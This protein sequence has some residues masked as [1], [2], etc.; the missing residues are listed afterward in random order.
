MKENSSEKMFAG[1]L[2]GSIALFCGYIYAGVKSPEPGVDQDLSSGLTIEK[3]ELKTPDGIT[4]RPKRYANPSG[5]PVL[6]LHGISGNGFEFDIPREEHNMAVFL[7][8]RGYDCWVSSF[9]GCGREPYLS[10][11]DDLSHSMDHLAIY[12]APTLVDGIIEKTGKKPFWIGHSMGGMTLYMYLQGARFEEPYHVVS[13]PDLVKERNSKLLGGIPIASP[14]AFRWSRAH[15]FNIAARSRLGRNLLGAGIALMRLGGLASPKVKI[16]SLALEVTG[17]RPKLIKALSRSPVGMQLYCRRN[18]DSDTTTS[19]I[20]WAGDDATVNMYIQLV[21]GIWGGNI[22]Q[23]FPFAFEGD[24]YDYTLN[25][26]LITLPMLFI[27]GEKDFASAECIRRYGYERISSEKKK[28]VVFPGYG[29]T[30]LVMG[31]N[32]ERDVYSVIADWMD[33][34]KSGLEG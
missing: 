11:T 10:D 16:G 23:Y 25:M 26:N 5:T 20:K 31:K 27:S 18:T 4:L 34:V 1:A 7:A 3:H 14:P 21:D 2:L 8:R 29:H 24:P 9:R 33:E 28:M 6:F 15:P 19:L 30:D 22:R 17:G 32:V 12:D 13:D